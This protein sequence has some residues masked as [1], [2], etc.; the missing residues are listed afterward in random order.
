MWH[1][2]LSIA[3]AITAIP[4]ATEAA[5]VA[6]VIK[7]LVCVPRLWCN[8]DSYGRGLVRVESRSIKTQYKLKFED[9]GL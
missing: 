4:A 9:E 2:V 3:L 6:N 1:V 8:W 7:G 5:P